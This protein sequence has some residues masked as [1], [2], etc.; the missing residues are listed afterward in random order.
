MTRGMRLGRTLLLAVAFGAYLLLAHLT[1]A[2]D[3]PSTLGALVAVVPYMAIAFGLAVRSKHRALALMLWTAVVVLLWRAWPLVE[4]RFEWIY[5][6]QHFGAFSL[7]AIGFGRSLVE[8]AEPMI[9]R[10]ARIVHGR[11]LAPALVRYTRRA[12]LAWA[13]FFVAI[14]ATSTLLFFAGSMQA[15][16]LLINLLTPI[17]VAAMFVV[18]FAVR[19][20]VLPPALRTGLADSVRAFIHASRGVTPPAA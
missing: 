17:L 9:T 13:L 8:G 14:A 11:E 15:W 6:I 7:L 3:Q 10:F 18:E 5:F 4:S 19:M 2:P 12:T 16:S 1:T 20:V